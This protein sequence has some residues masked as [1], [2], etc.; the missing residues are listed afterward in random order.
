MEILSSLVEK[1]KY[2]MPA[3]LVGLLFY[4]FNANSRY[5][6]EKDRYKER[7]EAL[8]A[9]EEQQL[10]WIDSLSVEY[11]LLQRKS[12]SIV[13]QR[14]SIYDVNRKMRK[15]YEKALSEIDNATGIDNSNW[16]LERYSSE[17]R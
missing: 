7:I 5:R 10:H 2:V 12:D 15:D 17:Q 3:L 1:S 13:M 4:T 11:T 8:K 6:A 14:D 9:L 16:F